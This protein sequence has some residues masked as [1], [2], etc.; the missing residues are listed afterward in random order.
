M[1]S[2]WSSV[3]CQF[4]LPPTAHECLF[5]LASQQ[6]FHACPPELETSISLNVFFLTYRS[7]IT[8]EGKHFLLTVYICGLLVHILCSFPT[9]Y[10]S[11]KVLSRKDHKPSRNWMNEKGL[12]WVKKGREGR[13]RKGG[14]K[15]KIKD[16]ESK[17]SYIK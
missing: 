13:R 5:L 14:R 15:R 4:T 16:Y 6:C 12:E 2:D 7:L 11:W 9:T 10:F 1:Y 3:F 17:S 8:R